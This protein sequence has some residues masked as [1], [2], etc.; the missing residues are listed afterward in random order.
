MA[1]K[2]SE[3]DFVQSGKVRVIAEEPDSAENKLNLTHRNHFLRPRKLDR[4]LFY[5]NHRNGLGRLIGSVEAAFPEDMGS[6][7]DIESLVN[8]FFKARSRSESF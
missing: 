1:K 2:S 6:K 8:V 7:Q 4:I 5:P 3:L